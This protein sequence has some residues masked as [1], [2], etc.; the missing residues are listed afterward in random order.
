MYKRQV[1]DSERVD[2]SSSTLDLETGGEKVTFSKGPGAIPKDK[3][4]SGSSSNLP[5]TPKRTTKHVLNKLVATP[6]GHLADQGR[7]NS[8]DMNT[9]KIPAMTPEERRRLVAQKQK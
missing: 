8:G 4:R 9:V 2:S 6:L 7:R 5:N 3:K 1:E